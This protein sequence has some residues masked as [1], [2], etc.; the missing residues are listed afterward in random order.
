MTDKI[1]QALH[2][3]QDILLRNL[4]HKP[5]DLMGLLGA[6]EYAAKT[7]DSAIMIV[8]AQVEGFPFVYCDKAF[9]KLTGYKPSEIIGNSPAILRGARTDPRMVDF[10]EDALASSNPEPVD[11]VIQHYRKDG[12][13]FWNKIHIVPIF[14]KKH[15]PVYFLKILKDVTH[16]V[17]LHQSLKARDQEIKLYRDRV[18]ELESIVEHLIRKSDPLRGIDV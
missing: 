10:I 2:H 8:D 3:K 18:Q 1:F 11:A 7:V 16:E 4:S 17:I 5:I 9:T 12:S 14:D 13:F 15:Q 6:H